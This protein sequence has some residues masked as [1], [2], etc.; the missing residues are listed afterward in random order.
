MDLTDNLLKINSLYTQW[1]ETAPLSEESEHKLWQKLRLEWNYNSNHIEGNTLTYGETQLLLIFDKTSGDHELR[2]FEEMKAHD[3]AVHSI[4]KWATDKERLITESDIRNL[5]NIIL[6]R[7]YW[8]EAL[9]YDGQSTRRL[10][11][12]GKYKEFPNSVRLKNGELFHYSAPSETPKLME[13]LMFWYKNND[14]EHPVIL[15]AELHY[16]FIRIHPFDDGNGRIARLL[17]NFELMRSGYPPIIVKAKDKEN[18]LTA[19]QKADVGDIAAFHDYIAVQ[20][21]WSFELALKA[22]R[23]ENIEE[24]DDLDKKLALLNV[25]LAQE[26]NLQVK[27]TIENQSIL[28]DNSIIPLIELIFDEIERFKG[29][30]ADIKTTISNASQSFLI[31]RNE[32]K[33]FFGQ[34]IKG[35]DFHRIQ[36]TFQFEGFKKAGTNTFS[37]HFT[38]DFEFDN[39]K[40]YI[41]EAASNYTLTGTTDHFT[42]L[43]KLYH[44]QISKEEM[45]SIAKSLANQLFSNIEGTLKQLKKI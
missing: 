28:I 6:V 29:L 1:C 37:K 21:I 40:Y 2:E 9:T 23:G 19:L 43:T 15:A 38:L 18:Y 42:L 25:S 22:A 35:L 14:I 34:N 31:N 5:N 33:D 44:Q 4:K 17:A 20:M 11:E 24:S 45:E 41:R 30:F 12:V 7:P 8:K 13:E 32:L 16:R 3:V 39:Y 26:D 10:I 27:R 36:V